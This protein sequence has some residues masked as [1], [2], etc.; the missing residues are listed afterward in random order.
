[1]NALWVNKPC[2][3]AP[4]QLV[5]PTHYNSYFSDTTANEYQF[6]SQMLYD[7]GLVGTPQNAR[8]KLYS[9][10]IAG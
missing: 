7:Q 4:Y 10:R 5:Q 9:S 6:C 1:M 8:V 3:V 2:F